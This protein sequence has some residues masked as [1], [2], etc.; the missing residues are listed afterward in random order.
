LGKR[1]MAREMAMQ[2]LFQSDLGVTPVPLVVQSFDPLEYVSQLDRER[3]EEPDPETGEVPPPPPRKKSQD[4]RPAA[5][6]APDGELRDAFEY[7][8]RLAEG[9]HEHLKEIDARIRAQADN[10]RLERMPS[11]DRN[12]LRIAIYELEHE[13]DVPK[14]VVVDE[15]V[16]LA[17]RYGSEQSGRF[18]NGLLDG[19]LKRGELGGS[20]Q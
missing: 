12:I 19:I 15:A 16:E 1:R 7:A 4:K 2:M 14:L 3:L 6:V 13:A 10:W 11:V 20:L 9:V 17:K 8:K 18:V 5:P